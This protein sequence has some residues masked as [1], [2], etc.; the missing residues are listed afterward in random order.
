MQYNSE[1]EVMKVLGIASWR[2]LSKD[3]FFRFLAMMPEI[4]KEVALKLIGQLP[5]ITTLARDALDDAGKAYNAAL[6]SNARIL[7]M[8][9]QVHLERLAILKAELDKD[10]SPEERMRVLDDIREVNL[11]AL[12]KDTENKK[13]LAEQFDKILGV[14]V[15]SAATLAA[16]VFAAIKSGHK[17][18][19]GAGRV[20]GS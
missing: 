12:L 2:N 16:V 5:E 10:P 11:S 13:F 7:E 18:G 14:V 4:D 1:V 20:F 9:H 8:V 6:A 17:P 15:A 3:T 19:V